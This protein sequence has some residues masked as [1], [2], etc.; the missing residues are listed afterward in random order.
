[1]DVVPGPNRSPLLARRR[2]VALY[3][4]RVYKEKE[5]EEG[6]ITSCAG[7]GAGERNR[8]FT[9][10]FERPRH[11]YFYGHYYAVQAMWTAGGRY[12]S[13][14]FPFVREEL[15]THSQRRA[16]D[17]SWHDTF[18]AITP[19]HGLYRPASADNYLPIS[20]RNENQK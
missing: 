6:L 17:G 7:S 2:V 15:L 13:E 8:N 10:T 3:S 18:A 1:M 4:A 5:V 19:L 14:W 9:M 11:P 20:C 16:G 12:W